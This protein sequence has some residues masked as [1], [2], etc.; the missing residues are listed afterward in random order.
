M[1][2][3]LPQPLPSG[4]E[5]LDSIVLTV[6]SHQEIPLAVD[7]DVGGIPESPRSRSLHAVADLEQDLAFRRI[8][9][10]T[11]EMRVGYQQPSQPSTVSPLGPSTLNSG[12]D[13]PRRYFP[14]RSNTWMR[15]VKS[16]R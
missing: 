8:D 11:I 1:A 3:P 12:V 15:S 5:N 9:Q 13:H 7:D 16:A 14:S 10:H 6:F 4:R 2:S